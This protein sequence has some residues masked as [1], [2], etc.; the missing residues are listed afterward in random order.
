MTK[1]RQTPRYARPASSRTA[2]ATNRHR[3]AR[4]RVFAE[5]EASPDTGGIAN[6]SFIAETLPGDGYD[7]I[8]AAPL[9]RRT[10]GSPHKA[11]IIAQQQ[12]ALIPQDRSLIY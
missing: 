7:P 12:Y 2:E 5:A 11:R 4:L 6:A 3:T 1:N 10:A 9:S 8:T